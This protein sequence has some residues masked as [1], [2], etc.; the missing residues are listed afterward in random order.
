MRTL[1]IGVATSSTARVRGFT[2][3][4]FIGSTSTASSCKT[5]QQDPSFARE[6][7][8]VRRSRSRISVTAL[9]LSRFR[10]QW[11]TRRELEIAQ[12]PNHG[13]DLE[14]DATNPVA[15]A[16]YGPVPAPGRPGPRRR[17]RGARSLRLRQLLRAAV[18]R[19]RP[20]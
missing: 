10:P 19:R 2:N 1:P 7:K 12:G 11:D 17:L 9:S 18:L 20:S 5:P 14:L 4:G 16:R 3:D 6:S 13:D 8:E 15:R